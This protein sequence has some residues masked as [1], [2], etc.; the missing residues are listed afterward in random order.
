MTCERRYTGVAIAELHE[1]A[2]L[3]VPGNFPDALYPILVSLARR[4]P[5]QE[6]AGLLYGVLLALQRGGVDVH[7][8]VPCVLQEMT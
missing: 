8:V 4:T 7:E 3:V 1:I 6:H 2:A 5:T